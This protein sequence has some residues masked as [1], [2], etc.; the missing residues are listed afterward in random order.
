MGYSTSEYVQ[1]CERDLARAKLVAKHYPNARQDGISGRQAWFDDSAIEHVTDFDFDVTEDKRSPDFMR[2][3]IRLIPYHRIR[4][5]EVEARVYASR[6]I[7][8]GMTGWEFLNRLQ[9]APETKAAILAMLKE[10][11]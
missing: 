3:T 11:R 8:G 9:A 4:S 5:G 7:S 2:Y 1:D 10:E 6:W